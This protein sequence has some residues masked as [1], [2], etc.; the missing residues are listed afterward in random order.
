M[1][2]A[3]NTFESIA[4]PRKQSL[5]GKEVEG[6]SSKRPC[7]QPATQIPTPSRNTAFTHEQNTGDH[8]A[9][10]RLLQGIEPSPN[11][12]LHP[13]KRNC[14]TNT[15]QRWLKDFSTETVD[16]KKR[17]ENIGIPNSGQQER[18]DD[19]RRGTSDQEKELQDNFVI[20]TIE[21]PLSLLEYP[22]NDWESDKDQMSR[23][24]SEIA[25]S[26]SSVQT[27]RLDPTNSAYIGTLKQNSVVVKSYCIIAIIAN[28]KD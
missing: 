13:S 19:I 15:L 2:F 3:C 14:Y 8:A 28:G 11:K 21:R 17:L 6:P 26:T 22:T 12:A 24:G 1:P 25:V 20:T 10:E 9:Y 23:T 7:Q 18:L 16:Q 27:E 4:S 5:E